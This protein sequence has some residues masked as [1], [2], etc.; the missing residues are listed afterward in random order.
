MSAPARPAYEV[1]FTDHA[2]ATVKKLDGSIK[3]SLRKSLEKKLAVDPHGYGTELRSPLTGHWKHEFFNH[4]VIYRIY[5][6]LR[7]VV[8]CAGGPRKSGDSQEVCAQLEPL[9]T[10]GR[11]AEQ[12]SALLKS[13][14]AA[15]PRDP[16]GPSLAR[17]PHRKKGQ[18]KRK[19]SCR[20]RFGVRPRVRKWSF[21]RG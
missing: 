14:A 3:K 20:Y 5:A 1:K 19:P 9:V 16:S 7:L 6:D 2:V 17:D 11:M 4:R 10:A 21:T 8:V 15:P 13:I 12:V 18:I